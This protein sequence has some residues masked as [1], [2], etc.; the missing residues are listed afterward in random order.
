MLAYGKIVFHICHSLHQLSAQIPRLRMTLEKPRPGQFIFLLGGP[1]SP[2]P[3]VPQNTLPQLVRTP[4][5]QR[6]TPCRVSRGKRVK[7][8]DGLE[9]WVASLIFLARACARYPRLG[10]VYFG[11]HSFMYCYKKCELA[12]NV[13]ADNVFSA[14]TSQKPVRYQLGIKLGHRPAGCCLTL[15]L[16]SE[17][18]ID[19]SSSKANLE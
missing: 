10:R 16:A 13:Y 8:R 5:T 1:R 17:V 9:V 3:A 2:S 19:G 6:T 14:S 7:E 18:T 12:S 15:T 4:R 11:I